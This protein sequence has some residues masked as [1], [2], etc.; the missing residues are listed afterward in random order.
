MDRGIFTIN[1]SREILNLD[2]VEGG[3][4]RTV[5]GE[6]KNADEVNENERDNAEN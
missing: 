1:E 4:V 5:R 3:D 6:Y 2:P